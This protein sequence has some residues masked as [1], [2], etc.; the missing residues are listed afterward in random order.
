MALTLLPAFGQD[1]GM[2]PYAGHSPQERKRALRAHV[3]ARRRQEVAGRDRA[4][5]A[6]WIAEEGLAAAATAGVDPGGWASV[7]ESLP[8]EPPTHALVGALLRHGIRVMVPVVLADLDLDWAEVGAGHLRLGREGIRDAGV[9]FVPALGVDPA[10]T[11]L[12]QGG[13]SYDRALPRASRNALLVAVVH[14]WEVLDTEL[15]SDEHDQ[16]VSAVL[17][18]G[19]R[20]TSLPA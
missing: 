11:R 19:R 2:D 4:A 6:A 16:P 12:G 7:F 10:G 3:R 17:A 13:G 18:A 8:L 5:D 1:V 14:P 15:P 20:L 9:V